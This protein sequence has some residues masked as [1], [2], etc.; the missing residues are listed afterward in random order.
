MD[1][2]KE[3]VLQLD[4]GPRRRAVASSCSCCLLG[5]LGLIVVA[6]V[7]ISSIVYQIASSVVRNVRE[8]HRALYHN[9]SVPDAPSIGPLLHTDTTFDIVATV[10][11]RAP[12]AEEREYNLAQA[13]GAED[14]E[15][16]Y[17]DSLPV[18]VPH[19]L[20]YTLFSDVVF[21]GLRMHNT[22]ANVDINFTLPTARLCVHS[23]LFELRRND[24]AS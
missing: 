8:P 9:T 21:R 4:P 17:D 7:V 24:A 18:D 12:L 16:V 5:I 10:W 23:L 11:V 22:D 2:D 20:E 13:G 3:S 1:T 15:K 6:A 14:A 19:L